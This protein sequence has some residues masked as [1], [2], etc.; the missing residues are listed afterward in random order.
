MKAQRA[1]R[2]RSLVCA[3]A[4]FHGL[5]GA[6]VELHCSVCVGE[7]EFNRVLQFGWVTDLFLEL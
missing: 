4:D 2:A 3:A 5:R 1:E 7:E 6:A